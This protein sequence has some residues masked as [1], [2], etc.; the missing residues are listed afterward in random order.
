MGNKKILTFWQDGRSLA[1]QI[2][3]DVVR[4]LDANPV[5]HLRF[6]ANFWASLDVGL[7][8][9]MR[10]NTSAMRCSLRLC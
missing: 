10:A 8:W 1:Y 7:R 6:F 5:F 4:S 3:F 2:G 9:T